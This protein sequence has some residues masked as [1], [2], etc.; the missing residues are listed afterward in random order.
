MPFEVNRACTSQT[1]AVTASRASTFDL[2]DMAM[3]VERF[4][5]QETV[6]SGEW[7]LGDFIDLSMYGTPSYQSNA[8]SPHSRRT[9]QLKLN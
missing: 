8:T 7:A 1:I 4:P 3:T 6:L 9:L 5:A 2:D